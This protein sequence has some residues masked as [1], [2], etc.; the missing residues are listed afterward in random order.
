ME[1]LLKQYVVWDIEL[2]KSR[3]KNNV[4]PKQ[5][6]PKMCDYYAGSYVNNND[7]I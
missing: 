2:R 3:V 1:K 6:I 7:G 4:E 5:G